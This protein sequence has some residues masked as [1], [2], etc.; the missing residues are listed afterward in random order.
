MARSLP[1]F[2]DLR[3]ALNVGVDAWTGNS[4]SGGVFPEQGKDPVAAL[5]WL[6]GG[7]RVGARVGQL[8]P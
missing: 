4:T 8:P 5:G 7:G 2:G 6:I 3:G 1:I